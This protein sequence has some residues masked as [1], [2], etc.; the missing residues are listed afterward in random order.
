MKPRA[1]WTLA[2]TAFSVAC[3]GTPVPPGVAVDPLLP[4]AGERVIVDQ[5]LLL[6][7]SSN[8]VGGEFPAER[9]LLKSFVGGMPDGDY[10]VGGISFGGFRRQVSEIERFD[11]DQLGAYA[12]HL[13]HLGEG[14]PL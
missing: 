4:S 7:D 11:R 2:L 9:E 5:A 3:A 13:E 1:T 12:T 10:E 8:S 6:I 14:T